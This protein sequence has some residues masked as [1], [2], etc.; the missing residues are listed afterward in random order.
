[1]P[2]LPWG[3]LVPWAI[4]G[5]PDPPLPAYDDA[6]VQTAWVAA[7]GALDAACRWPGGDPDA[8][9][10]PLACDD[11]ALDGVIL[12]IDQLLDHL[13]DD[14]RLRTLRALA[15]RF[16]NHP[17]RA[18]ADLQRAAALAPDRADVHADLGELLSSRGDLDGARAAF[19]VV[20]RAVPDGPTAWYGWF[21]LAQLDARTGDAEAMEAHLRQALRFGFR[22]RWMANNPLWVDAYATPRLRA[23]LDRLGRGYGDDGA[24]ET[25]R[26]PDAPRSPR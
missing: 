2:G 3:V 8:G 16:R 17:E 6:V 1:M 19:E 14:A 22:F 18:I 9:H 7:E 5:L 23:V 12:R 15:H 24:L 10:P 4:A 25:L 20:T 21:Q 11:D 13:G 26:P